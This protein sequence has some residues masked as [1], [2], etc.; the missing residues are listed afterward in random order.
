MAKYTE[1]VILVIV[2]MF[3]QFSP[4]GRQRDCNSC[5][6]AVSSLVPLRAIKLLAE[7]KIKRSDLKAI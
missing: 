7:L 6:I 4:L 3:R 2:L 5:L 1:P